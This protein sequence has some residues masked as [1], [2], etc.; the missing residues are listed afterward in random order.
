MSVFSLKIQIINFEL[1]L[2][3]MLLDT[4]WDFLFANFGTFWGGWDRNQRN[5]CFFDDKIKVL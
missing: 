4:I 5:C 2:Q 1:F 3:I